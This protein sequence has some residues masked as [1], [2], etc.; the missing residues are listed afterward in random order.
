MLRRS[1]RPRFAVRQADAE[2]DSDS[3]AG[4][5]PS[6]WRRVPKANTKDADYVFLSFVTQNLPRGVV[7][8]SYLR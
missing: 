2:S 4:Q 5:K 6:S 7:G 8:A 1:P 3:R